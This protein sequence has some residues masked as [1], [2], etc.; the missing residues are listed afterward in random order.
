MAGAIAAELAAAVLAH[1]L[2]V[3]APPPP[4]ERKSS[5]SSPS[6]D[7]DSE[8]EEQ[9]LD[10]PL[11]EPAHMVRGRLGAAFEQRAMVAEAFDG[12]TACSSRAVAAYRC[13]GAAFVLDALRDPRSLEELTGLDELQASA[14]AMAMAV[15]SEEEEEEEEAGNGERTKEGDEEDEEWTEL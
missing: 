8:S 1:P 4:R 13:R 15:S 14:E 3:R 11:G 6:S 7:S 12:C 2:G 10:L 5:P 9:E